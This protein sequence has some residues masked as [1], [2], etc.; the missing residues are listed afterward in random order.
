MDRRTGN[1]HGLIPDGG[2]IREL[3]EDCGLTVTQLAR[4]VGRSADFVRRIEL[5]GKPVSKVTASRIA[6]TLSVK[7]EV[8]REEIL[9][10]GG[11]DSESDAETKVPAA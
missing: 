5:Y 10:S 3:R 8:T 9:A 2:K 11:D 7:R 4:A 6:N 1:P